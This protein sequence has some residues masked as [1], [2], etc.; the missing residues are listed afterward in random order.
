[1]SP[2]KIAT[3]LA[4][5]IS[6]IAAF[7]MIP[8]AALMLVVL[9]LAAGSQWSRDDSVRVIVTAM[10]LVGVTA[11]DAVPQ[12]GTQ[13]GAILGNVGQVAAGASIALIARNIWARLS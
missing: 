7:V 9:G 8:Y 13:L 3:W 6:V 5:A 10:F 12:V 4:L 2:L 11:L 1:M